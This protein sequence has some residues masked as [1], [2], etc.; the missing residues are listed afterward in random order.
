MTPLTLLK[1]RITQWYTK[2]EGK[3]STTKGYC[4]VQQCR[5]VRPAAPQHLK[6]LPNAFD[7]AK[8]GSIVSKQS[9][10]SNAVA[11]NYGCVPRSDREALVTNKA[12]PAPVTFCCEVGEHHHRAFDSDRAR[13]R[14]CQPFDRE[15]EEI[16][17]RAPSGQDVSC[18]VARALD[19]ALSS[20]SSTS[21][22]C[23]RARGTLVSRTAMLC[24]RC[25]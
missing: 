20:W 21:G 8:L 4:D 6:R 2:A 5:S 1:H 25:L 14:T 7:N 19:D 13:A 15:L 18:S 24:G 9:K 17:L 3:G 22:P 11:A 23:R 12:P 10:I 16:C